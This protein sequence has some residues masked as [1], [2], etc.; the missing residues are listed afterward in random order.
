[1]RRTPNIAGRLWTKVRLAPLRAAVVAFLSLTCIATG[2]WI[3][4]PTR[5][6]PRTAD[7]KPNLSAPAP[8]TMDGKP[9]LSGIWE[10]LNARTTA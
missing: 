9:D 6:I 3:N 7:G 8:R 2:Q 10:Q 5:A 4:Y 1:M